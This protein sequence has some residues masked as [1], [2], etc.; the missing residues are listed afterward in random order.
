MAT[1]PPAFPEEAL[2]APER[3]AKAPHTP[4]EQHEAFV[5]EFGTD[6]IVVPGPQVDEVLRRL[7]DRIALRADPEAGPSDVPAPDLPD[8]LLDSEGVGI[9]SL[10]G[11]GVALYPDYHLAEAAFADPALV[12]R[13]RPRETLT[14]LLEDPEI[15]PDAL[16]RLA[17]RAPDAAS[18]IFARLLKRKGFS[19]PD[20]GE[21]LLREYKPDHFED[22]AQTPGTV[23]LSPETGENL[24]DSGGAVP[25]P[26]VHRIKVSLA[27]ARPPIWRRLEVPSAIRLR[28]LHLVFQTAFAWENYHMWLFETPAGDFGVPDRE[29]GHRNA[30]AVRLDKIAPHPRD[31]FAYV[32]DFG[33]DWGHK[34]LVEA[35][36]PAEPGVAYPRCL[37]GRR[38][39]PPE[40][41][42]GIW[43]YAD[44]LDVLADPEHE[45]H[46][47][48]LEWLNLDSPD[49]FDPAAFDAAEINREL[50]EG[51]P[52]P[53]H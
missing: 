50:S 38:A 32:Y 12:A 27:G 22:D 51:T 14:E 28:D 15:P 39:A 25:S 1:M 37:T 10:Q 34:V 8:F 53:R 45:N 36:S 7:Y 24:P 40:D 48:M 29:L 26:T 20:E 3:Q 4:A 9:H 47:D 19:W 46:Q 31:E 16:R 49:D 17:D 11:A 6:L 33:D 43:G 52:T 21:E 2:H 41:C 5:E 44:L 42:G 35:V 18:K 13:R 30:A 23:V